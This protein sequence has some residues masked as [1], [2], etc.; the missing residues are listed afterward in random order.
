MSNEKM[1]SN[2]EV[3]E[4]LKISTWTLI[5]WYQWQKKQIAKGLIEEEYLPKPIKLEHEKGKPNKWTEE[6]IEQLKNYQSTIV[7]GRNGIYGAY[8]NPLHFET[9]KFKNSTETV[10][11]Q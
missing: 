8:T 3:C 1:Y 9:K 5:N 2:N 11:K 7:V 4:I 6:M 10:D